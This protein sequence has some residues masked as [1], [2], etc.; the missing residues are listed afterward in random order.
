MA[1]GDDKKIIAK[2]GFGM[3]PISTRMQTRYDNAVQTGLDVLDGNLAPEEVELEHLSDLKG[4]FNRCLR[5][6]QWDWFSVFTDL[7]EPK[8]DDLKVLGHGIGLLRRALKDRAVLE[9]DRCRHG[10]IGSNVLRYLLAWQDGIQQTS[11]D[12][13]SGWLYILSTR[14]QPE[15]LKIGMTTRNVAQRV[16]EINSATGVLIPYAARKVFRVKNA[17][18]AE[19][20]LFGVLAPHRIRPDREFFRLPFVAAIRLIEDYLEASRMQARKEGKV[21]WFDVTRQYGFVAADGSDDFFLHVSQLEDVDPTLLLP[22][23]PIEFDAGHRPQ[24]P[25]ALRARLGQP[26]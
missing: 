20:E 23:T 18:I 19:R 2:W 1:P 3:A 14:E 15:I 12:D 5:Q 26:R 16:R 22:G 8:H 11:S 21:V 24:G 9:I 25:C 17:G 7:G 6:D 4:M 13:G 10:L